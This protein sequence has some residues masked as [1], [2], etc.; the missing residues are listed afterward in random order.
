[1]TATTATSP[2]TAR[3]VRQGAIYLPVTAAVQP[4]IA[5]LP[6]ILS[7]DFGLSLAL[8]GTLYLAGQ[9]L[10]G[11]LEPVVGTLSD[12]TRSRFG[13]RR[14]WIAGGGVLF[15]IGAAML[16]FPSDAIGQFSARYRSSDR[17]HRRRNPGRDT[18]R[19]S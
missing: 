13:R 16:F 19:R 11:F 6:A 18:F 7:R 12:R 2:S 9:L 8:V 14:P 17:Q 1:M 10:N 3:L 5:W 4:V 15:T